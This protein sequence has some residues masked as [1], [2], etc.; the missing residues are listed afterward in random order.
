MAMTFERRPDG[1]WAVFP[2]YLDMGPYETRQQALD[3]CRGVQQFDLAEGRLHQ[4][5]L[6]DKKGLPGQLGLFDH[7]GD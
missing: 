6:I 5:A 1:W 2:P 4:R 7:I 3:E